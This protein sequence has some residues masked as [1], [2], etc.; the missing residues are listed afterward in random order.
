MNATIITNLGKLITVPIEKVDDLDVPA[1]FE[2]A[3]KL[4]HR[5]VSRKVK[6]THAG[7]YQ[8][9]SLG[10]MVVDLNDPRPC[11]VA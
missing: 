5:Y 6:T 3:C 8:V 2:K 1:N 4:V 7:S 11:I 10:D 9:R